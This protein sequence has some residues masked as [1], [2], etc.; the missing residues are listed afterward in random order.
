MH[1]LLGLFLAFLS[2]SCAGLPQLSPPQSQ[3]DKL[4]LD[5][6]RVYQMDL[7]LEVNGIKSQGMI[8]VPQAERYLLKIKAPGDSDVVTFTSCNREDILRKQDDQFQYMYVPNVV[9]SE[10][11]PVLINAYSP[12]FRYSGGYFEA[13]PPN[14][15][16]STVMCNGRVEVSNGLYLCQARAGLDVQLIFDN[17]VISATPSL[18]CNAFIPDG[19]KWKA[20]LS[21]GLCTYR[22]REKDG[23]KKYFRIVTHGYEEFNLYR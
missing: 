16:R 12:K 13:T 8:T 4:Q 3:L 21:K 19:K 9:E 18:G 15:A 10:A 7:Q 22:F 20:S 23:L 14:W 6:N 1:Y 5:T 17:D 11:C 2:V